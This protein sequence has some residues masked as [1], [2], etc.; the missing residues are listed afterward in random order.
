MNE[1]DFNTCLEDGKS[2]EEIPL[3][4]SGCG[5]Y[6]FFKVRIFG[7]LQLE[8]RISPLYKDDNK[9]LEALR[10][11]LAIGLQLNH[12][13]IVRYHNFSGESL[14]EEFIEG[15]TL[16]ELIEK[17]DE[18]LSDK[19]FVREV[20]TQLLEALDYIH[21][22]GIIHHD[23]KP[24]NIMITRIGNRVKIIDFGAAVSSQNDSSPGFTKSY[25]APEEDKDIK[26]CRSDLYQLG[27]TLKELEFF[28]KNRK[29]IKFI[30]KLINENPEL[31]YQSAQQ[32]LDDF[33]KPKSLNDRMSLQIILSLM[34]FIFL[35]FLV[36]FLFF[37]RNPGVSS[38]EN[39]PISDSSIHKEESVVADIPNNESVDADIQK[40]ESAM[41]DIQKEASAVADPKEK[42]TLGNIESPVEESPNSLNNV[43]DIIREKITKTSNKYFSE[44]II[45]FMDNIEN[46]S[47]S[48]DGQIYGADSVCKMLEFEIIRLKDDLIKKYPQ[49]KN[50]IRE[51]ILEILEKNRNKVGWMLKEKIYLHP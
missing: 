8:K 22:S 19:L 15:L 38:E 7:S 16:R 51:E 24:E 45:P 23:I 2:G 48:S 14:Y 44:K 32:A 29:Y 6:V 20:V 40:E 10:K 30:E 47:S 41:T 1:S 26:D 49:E 50:F 37:L 31:R 39:I 12:P 28:H 21:K 18:R 46:Y 34:G 42:V 43:K 9:T 5:R 13:G 36:T 4:K 27:Y 17:K 33:V 3:F 11:E 35:G 25:K